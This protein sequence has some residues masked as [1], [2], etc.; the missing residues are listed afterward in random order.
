MTATA[1]PRQGVSP[2]EG[3]LAQSRR[4][5]AAL[6]LAGPMVLVYEVGTW[7]FHL[8]AERRTETRIVAFNWVRDAFDLLGASGGLIAPLAVIGLLLGWHVFAGHPWR[9]RAG[10]V[11]GMT[12]ES[13]LLALPLLPIAAAVAWLIP[14]GADGVTLLLPAGVEG[15]LG[16]AVLGVGAGVYEEL[17]FRLVGFAVLHTLLIDLLRLGPRQAFVWTLLVTS[18]AFSLYHYVPAGGEPWQ[19]GSFA[20]RF[21]AG[22]YLGLVYQ[23]RGFGIAAGAHAAYDVA[24][25]FAGVRL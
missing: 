22:A 23:F 14:R 13:V 20:F 16:Q 15:V 19:L 4:P 7:A 3:Y 17:V 12:A 24:L 11:L 21:A 5:L 25:A 10:V 18:L 2:R 1:E 8:D 6:A 9:L